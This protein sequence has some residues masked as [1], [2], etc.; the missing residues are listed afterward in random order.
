M[1]GIVWT[2][3]RRTQ[4]CFQSTGASWWRS[5]GSWKIWR[6]LV[7]KKQTALFAWRRGGRDDQTQAPPTVQHPKTSRHNR[8]LGIWRSPKCGPLAISVNKTACEHS[9]GGNSDFLEVIAGKLAIGLYH[10]RH[11][12]GQWKGHTINRPQADRS[13]VQLPATHPQANST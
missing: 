8:T 2:K 12:Q 4:S 13:G 5:W 6:Q 10:V 9:C 7:N 11:S 3:K 1:D